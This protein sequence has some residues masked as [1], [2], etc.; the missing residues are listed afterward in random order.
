MDEDVVDVVDV[1]GEP[2]ET[3]DKFRPWVGQFS[4]GAVAAV[5]GAGIA[6][7][8]WGKSW[9]AV[10][11]GLFAVMLGYL[12]GQ[13][14]WSRAYGQKV[15]RKAAE[16]IKWPKDWSSR[17]N[18]VFR[19]QEGGPPVEVDLLVQGP[20]GRR[21]I[22]EIKSQSNIEVNRGWFGKSSVRRAG[23]GRFTVDPVNQ[24]EVAAGV[25]GGQAVLW[26]PQAPAV[27]AVKL[28]GPGK[29]LVVRGNQR[30]L[31]RALGASGWFW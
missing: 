8:F 13:K 7:W 1:S 20:G 25:A 9:Y 12:W 30:M 5:T 17:R 18:V 6:W 23:G 2:S 22:V 3:A 10:A 15:E 26:F 29:V 31:K 21:F 4:E 16:S 11:V 14:A 27:S 24:V 28:R 19:D